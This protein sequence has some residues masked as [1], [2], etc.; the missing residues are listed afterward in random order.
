MP[1]KIS[2]FIVLATA[3]IALMLGVARRNS[4][5]IQEVGAQS[6]PVQTDNLAP[7]D[8]TQAAGRSHSVP[9]PRREISRRD[10]HCLQLQSTVGRGLGSASS[11][12]SLS[13]QG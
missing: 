8:A 13:R 9:R 5:E 1:S 4:T 2:K 3:S 11:V 6:Q 10:T 7:V 12:V